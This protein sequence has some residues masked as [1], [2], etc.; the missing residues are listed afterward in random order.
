M[1][2]CAAATA[3]G[4]IARKK[5]FGVM[6]GPLL[7]M[8]A[9]ALTSTCMPELYMSIQLRRRRKCFTSRCARDICAP[10]CCSDSSLSPAAAQN[11]QLRYHQAHLCC[12]LLLRAEGA[13]V[14]AVVWGAEQCSD[15]L[16][17]SV[18]LPGGSR[19]SAKASTNTLHGNAAHMHAP[20]WVRF[21]QEEF[22][23]VRQQWMRAHAH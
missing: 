14:H 8:H 19:A 10:A 11:S 1:L 12:C 2:T 16:D 22:G 21:L 17:G 7:Q 13:H 5:N 18:T 3:Q 9:C 20:G 6:K 23:V 4:C 15:L